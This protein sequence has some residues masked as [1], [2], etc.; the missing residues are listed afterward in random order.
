MHEAA[1]NAPRI[2][3]IGSIGNQNEETSMS[4]RILLAVSTGAILACHAG[5]AAAQAIPGGVQPG[6]IEKQFDTL[7]APKAGED[8]V[9]PALPVL[10]PGPDAAAVRFVLRSVAIDGATVY[11]ADSLAREFDPLTGKET[12]LAELYAVAERITARYRNDGYILTQ[13]VV[14]A[15]TVREGAVRIQIV[16]GFID[17]IRFEGESGGGR[18]LLERYAEKIRA[19]RPLRADTLERYLLLM[20]DLPGLTARAT[21]A[22]SAATPGASDMTISLGHARFEGA[23]TAHNRGSRSLGPWRGEFE[24]DLNSVL[25]LHE[26]TSIRAVSSFDRELNF[27][28]LAHEHPVGAEGGRLGLS[29]SGV[30]SI[31]GRAANLNFDGLETSSVSGAL[32]Y[33]HPLLRTRA[34]NLYLRG[35]LTWFDGESEFAATTLTEDRIRALRLGLTWDMADRWRGVNIVDLELGQGI[36]ALGARRSGSANL[37]RADGRSDFTKASLYAARLQSLAPNWSLLVAASG[38]RAF[39]TLLSPELFAYGAEP[40][41]RGH[42]ASELVGDSGAAGK[43]E[44]RWAGQADLGVPAGYTVYGFYDAGKVWRRD[45]VNQPRAE[46]ATSA[47]LGLRFSVARGFTG[48]VELAKPLTRDVAAEGDRDA[49]LFGALA[50]RF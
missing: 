45:P 4:R 36:D 43:L 19:A 18:A 33:R 40:F 17:A 26:R 47:G 41:G 1:H 12:S 27:A 5:I 28:A 50:Y 49:R 25:G 8:A 22:A 32:A 48:F 35:A 11:P 3:S 30:S 23:L 34:H 7:P 2:V 29:I 10:K 42:D 14:P 44:L 20:N 6:Q 9:I 24:L 37:S 39:S 15:Q 46:S 31:P 21:L 38:Q 13:A 16:E